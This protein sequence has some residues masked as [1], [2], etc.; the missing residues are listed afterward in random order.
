MI[1]ID[2]ALTR[3]PVSRLVHF[4]SAV[5]LDPI[6]RDGAIRN[7]EDLAAN[8]A[9]RYSPT[10]LQRY[11]GR[12]SHVCSSFEYPNAYYHHQAKGK[13]EFI[14][15]PDWV[16]LILNR[17]LVRRTG[18]LFSSCNAATAGGA[19]LGEGGQAMLDCWGSKTVDGRFPRRSTHLAAVPTDLQAEV[20]IPGSIDLSEVSAIVTKSAERARELFGTLQMYGLQPGRMEWR[21]APMFFD[22]A[23]LRS[24]IWRGQRV[25]EF[26]WTPTA[27]DLA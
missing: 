15:Y 2:E 10:D 20:L 11:D 8:A 17:D 25:P 5:N 13:A 24:H 9:D 19:Y 7:S 23:Q 22:R 12:P 3:V 1:P 4:T 18:T 26:V 27:E 21:Y 14:N 16:C 6:F